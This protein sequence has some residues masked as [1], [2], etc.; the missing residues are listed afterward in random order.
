M[1]PFILKFKSKPNQKSIDY[2]LVEYSDTLNL[3]VMSKSDIPAVKF[4]ELGT[5]TFTKTEG[6][7]SDTDKSSMRSK[8]KSL[9]DTSTQ[10]YTQTEQ[11]DA[12][13]NIID[14]FKM[15]MDTTTLTEAVEGSD[16][17]K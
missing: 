7:G 14:R 1:E 10:T 16:S 15:L 6:E 8:L 3:S 11:S 9:L 4:M 2:S 12:D 13:R 17:D 5:E